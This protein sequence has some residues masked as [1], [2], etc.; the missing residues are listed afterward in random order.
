MH[1]FASPDEVTRGAGAS[2]REPGAFMERQ[3]D[4]VRLMAEDGC[5][6]NFETPLYRKDE[7]LSWVSINAR[8]VRDEEG[9]VSRYEG[10]VM[11]ISDKKM[12]EAQLLQAQ[13][14]EAVGTLAGGVAHD[15][16][17]ILMALMGYANLL[18]MKM[19][20]RDP[21][22]S[23]VDQILVSTEKAARLTQSLLTFSRK[24]MMELKPHRVSDL[25]EGR[26]RSYW[27]GSCPKT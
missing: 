22:R 8:A 4:Y 1:G 9:R 14:M 24:Q 18:Q 7:R 6:V 2:V 13:K 5:V 25:S 21:L 26:R 16:N 17:N 27:R 23:Y 19:E 3:K 15:F 12:L 11:D 10:S 20:P